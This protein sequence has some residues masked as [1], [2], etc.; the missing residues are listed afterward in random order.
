MDNQ[1]NPQSDVAPEVHADYMIFSD[2]ET[3]SGASDSTIV[4]LHVPE[5]ELPEETLRRI[6]DSADIGLLYD[7]VKEGRVRGT[8]INV[9]DLLKLRDLVGDIKPEDAGN[10]EKMTELLDAI[11]NLDI[12]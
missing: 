11:G 7:D 8:I 12:W 5:E 6:R 4:L 2:G 3:W 10:K 1:N 9:S